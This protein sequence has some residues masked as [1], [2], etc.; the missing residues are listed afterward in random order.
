MPEPKEKKEKHRSE[1]MGP[2]TRHAPSELS[3]V[4]QEMAGMDASEGTRALAIFLENSP[5][6]VL[7]FNDAGDIIAKNQRATELWNGD[8]GFIPP[9]LVNAVS[10]VDTT[11]HTF[12][13]EKK[14]RLVAIKA[15]GGRRYFLPTV[16]PL[17]EHLN[18]GRKDGSGRIVACLLKDETMWERTERIRKNLLASISH[19]LNT[20]LTS[21]RLALYL[22]AEQQIGDLNDN[23]QDLVERAKQDLD[24]EIVSIQNV[25]DMIRSD[26]IEQEAS[27]AEELNLH[28]LAEETISAFDSQ[29]RMMRLPVRRDYTADSPWVSMERDTAQLVIHQ[30]FASILKYTS[31]NADLKITTSVQDGHCLLELTIENSGP[32]D[33]P[34][35][36]LFSME[37]DNPGT[38]RLRCA[39]LGLRVAHEMVTP[40]GGSLGSQHLSTSGTLRFRYPHTRR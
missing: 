36:D 34:T 19:E 39:D 24:R 9:Q 4:L 22:L 12:H 27:E 20:P 14:N 29:I 1:N 7:L 26:G 40:Y 16:F 11:G 37:M 8:E 2:A 33:F 23:Q 5:D 6:P 38:R 17:S 32:A 31:E 28:E 15:V 18:G 21:A 10:K 13:E 25:I 3:H 35:N 30:L